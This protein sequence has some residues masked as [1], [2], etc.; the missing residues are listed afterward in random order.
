M[1]KYAAEKIAS[2]YYNMGIQL[3]LQ[4][5]GLVK[6]ASK[7]KALAALTGLSGAGAAGLV[8]AEQQLLARMGLG[9]AGQKAKLLA[10]NLMGEGGAAARMAARAGEEGA[11]LRAGMGPVNPQMA[12]NIIGSG[13]LPGVSSAESTGINELFGLRLDEYGN[14][15]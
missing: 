6:T 12:E 11:V 15:M 1:N 14:F 10:A 2:E 9:G 13:K 8:G 4:N 5:A 3:A 7:A